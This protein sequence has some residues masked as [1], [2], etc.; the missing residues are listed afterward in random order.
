MYEN[1]ICLRTLYSKVKT[2]S[3]KKHVIKKFQEAAKLTV[4]MFLAS[5]KEEVEE[6]VKK[7]R[8][9]MFSRKCPI[10]IVN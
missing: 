4:N 3:S 6:G 1:Q 2:N 10:I 7:R 5:K 9:K 8:K